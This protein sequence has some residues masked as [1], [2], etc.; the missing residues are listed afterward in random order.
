MKFRVFLGFH[1][2]GFSFIRPETSVA[3]ARAGQQ[4][5]VGS[6]AGGSRQKRAIPAGWAA[7]AEF[8]VCALPSP[9]RE[10]RESRRQHE[11]VSEPQRRQLETEQAQPCTGL[12]TR[13]R[14]VA[15]PN[16]GRCS[17]SPPGRRHTRNAH[18]RPAVL[19]YL[20]FLTPL[21]C[22]SKWHIRLQ[23]I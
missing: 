22:C 16:P 21:F 10:R 5:A 19:S 14:A 17:P 15:P 9:T 1:K 18:R 2:T 7:A 11:G 20:P 13:H 3:M 8:V 4:T 12:C 23:P 6:S